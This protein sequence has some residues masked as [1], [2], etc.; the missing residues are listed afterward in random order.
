MKADHVKTTETM[1]VVS[2]HP[3]EKGHWNQ[4]GIETPPVP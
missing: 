2:S 1:E 4:K 3:G